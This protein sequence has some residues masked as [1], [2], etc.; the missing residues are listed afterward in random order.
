M[1]GAEGPHQ[2]LSIF[3]LSREN[4]LKSG[5]IVNISLFVKILPGQAAVAIV[6]TF[7]DFTIF[8]QVL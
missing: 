4:I 1:F 8:D 5:C 6:R 7:G 2:T 3:T